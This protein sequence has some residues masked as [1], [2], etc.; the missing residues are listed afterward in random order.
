MQMTP[1]IYMQVRDN[2]QTS[3]HPRI[4]GCH[5]S[6]PSERT[7]AETAAA[8]RLR[9]CTLGGGWQELYTRRSTMNAGDARQ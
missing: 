1:Y 2:T 3:I 8:V 7:A 6:C 4:R 9:K 5:V